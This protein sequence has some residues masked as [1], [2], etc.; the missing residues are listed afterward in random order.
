MPDTTTRCCVVGGGP[1][2]M[3]LGFLLARAGIDVVVLEKHADF[4]RDFRGDT[5]HPS[6]MQVMHELGILDAFLARPHSEIRTLGL[7][8][9]D[10]FLQVA[11]FSHLPT[12]A[13][14]IAFMPQWDFLDF[15]TEQA[16]RFPT[17]RLMMRTEAIDLIREGDQMIGVRARGPDGMLDIHAQLI[18]ACDGRH[19]TLRD[20]AGFGVVEIGA[21]MDVLWLRLSK[22]PTDPA[23]IL[24][25]IDAGRVFIMLDRNDYWQC[26]F[27]IPKGG[28][29][30]V[31]ASGLDAFRAEIVRL[32]SFLQDRVQELTTWDDVKLLTVAVNRLDTWFRPG[33]L[34]IGDAAHAMSPVGGVGINLAIQDAV[35]TAN[36]LVPRLTRGQVTL[37]DLRAVQRRRTWP[38]RMTQRLQVAVQNRI[39]SNVLRT[40]ATP[41]PPFAARMLGR[42]PLLRR[43]PARII[44]MGFRPEH[45]RH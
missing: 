3:M 37:E 36:V 4:L 13:K 33:L 17:F 2:G 20:A 10:T 19:S 16:N 23:Q 9:G 43:L 31:H 27:V 32:A 6:T 40:T 25:R 8:I 11:D 39:I 44:G 28:I 21:P 38:T 22:H 42:F 45:I 24:G 14:F 30:E 41:A 12:Q 15:L 29:D 34:C 5:V 26:A 18:I 1:A 7:Q 35:A